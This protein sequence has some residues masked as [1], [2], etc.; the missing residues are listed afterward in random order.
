M[1]GLPCLATAFLSPSLRKEAKSFPTANLPTFSALVYSLSSLRKMG[2]KGRELAIDESNI[3]KVL[4]CV[5]MS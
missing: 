1:A 4:L 5:S 2:T 3:A